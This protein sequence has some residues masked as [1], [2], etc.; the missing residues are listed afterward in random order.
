MLLKSEEKRIKIPSNLCQIEGWMVGPKT[1]SNQR[2][3]SAVDWQFNLRQSEGK[4]PLSNGAR[5]SH[6]NPKTTENW[7]QK[8]RQIEGQCPPFNGWAKVPYGPPKKSLKS[9]KGHSESPQKIIANWIAT[10]STW[11]TFGSETF[12]KSDKLEAVWFVVKA[13]KPH[14]LGGCLGF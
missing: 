8:L 4:S 14:G 6:Q 2:A 11:N 10:S 9:N 5:P 1:L 12:Q 13:S 3:K 7:G